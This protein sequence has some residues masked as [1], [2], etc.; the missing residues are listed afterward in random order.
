MAFSFVIQI[1]KE[2]KEVRRER[3]VES[4]HNSCFNHVQWSPCICG[5]MCELLWKMCQ[6]SRVQTSGGVFAYY[7]N[8]RILINTIKGIFANMQILHH[9]TKSHFKC[10]HVYVIYY[11]IYICNIFINFFQFS[12]PVIRV[13][14]KVTAWLN[15]LCSKR[16]FWLGS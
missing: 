1:P 10:E 3:K 14:L 5:R 6:T 4:V 15:M 2:Q 11:V 13:S 8:Q 12:L 16:S 9:C 7:V